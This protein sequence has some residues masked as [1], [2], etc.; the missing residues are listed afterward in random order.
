MTASSLLATVQVSHS[1]EYSSGTRSGLPVQQVIRGVLVPLVFVP[2]DVAHVSLP[3]IAVAFCGSWVVRCLRGEWPSEPDAG[4][5]DDAGSGEAECC[6][7]DPVV[8]GCP[9]PVH[10]VGVRGQDA[11]QCQGGQGGKGEGQ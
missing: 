9:G 1:I 7:G 4:V 10:A 6:G 3:C 8:G 11:V 5:Q 2:R